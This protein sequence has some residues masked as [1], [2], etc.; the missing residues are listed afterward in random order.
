MTDSDTSGSEQSQVSIV[1]Q[2]KRTKVSFNVPQNIKCIYNV[3]SL[4]LL[5][6]IRFT[7]RK[8]GGPIVI[9]FRYLHFFQN[10]ISYSCHRI[11]CKFGTGIL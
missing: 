6:I 10:T 11:F 8:V 4:L 1:F 2:S 7:G 5:T 9:V 3:H